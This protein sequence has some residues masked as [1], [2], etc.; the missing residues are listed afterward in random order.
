MLPKLEILSVLFFLILTG[1]FYFRFRHTN[2][3]RVLFLSITLLFIAYTQGMTLLYNYPIYNRV[4]F[5]TYSEGIVFYLII[6][7]LYMYLLNITYKRPFFSPIN[8]INIL[9]A[10]PGFIFVVY[11]NTLS[12]QEQ[13]YSMLV[14]SCG[15]LKDNWLSVTG[16]IIQLFYLILII[17][18][19]R[20]FIK[21]KGSELTQKSLQRLHTF[22]WVIHLFII[23]DVGFAVLLIIIPMLQA[24]NNVILAL[25][26]IIFSGVYYLA[27]YDGTSDLQYI[28]AKKNQTPNRQQPIN[29]NFND[30][31]EV[32]FS[33]LERKFLFKI[34]L[35]SFSKEINI[36]SY[37]VS[38]CIKIK[39]N[40]SF[41]DYLN[42]L[43]IDYSKT[44]IIAL[45]DQFIKMD[46]LAKECGFS[47]RSSFYAEFKKKMGVSPA[48]YK[49]VVNKE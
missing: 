16:M 31:S 3:N 5:V 39:Y 30:V 29:G 43:R 47:S 24:I 17:V 25:N 22:S 28:D 2:Y 36:P 34:N 38:A 23:L 35:I 26:I 49:K 8:A 19:L 32:I 10:I 13:E 27:I 7:M 33:N 1:I 12:L 37:K 20:A 6:P 21:E 18:R 41:P 14:K 44:R 4:L 42:T 15:I 46:Y 40:M 9:P 45:K 11:F 48:E